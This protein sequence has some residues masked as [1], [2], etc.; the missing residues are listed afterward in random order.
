M[1]KARKGFSRRQSHPEWIGITGAEE[2]HK[3]SPKTYHRLFWGLTYQ[4]ELGFNLKNLDCA[5][6]PC[7]QEKKIQR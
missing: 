1:P 2:V 7:V 3:G 5:A 4:S 6:A